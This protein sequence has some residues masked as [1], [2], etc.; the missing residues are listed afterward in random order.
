[1]KWNSLFLVYFLQNVMLE[2][3]WTN[4]NERNDKY[5]IKY[6]L[7]FDEMFVINE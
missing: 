6:T 1:M 5:L 4:S 7:I 2:E 3:L